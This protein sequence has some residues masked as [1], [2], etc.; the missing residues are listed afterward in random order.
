MALFWESTFTEV[1]GISD[2]PMSSLD[3]SYLAM[4]LE[5]S[6]IN[7]GDVMALEVTSPG[8]VEEI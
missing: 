7:G 1:P 8:R 4:A 5:V 3:F 2:K 6:L